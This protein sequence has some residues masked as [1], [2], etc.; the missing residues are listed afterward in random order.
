MKHF[1]TTNF[2]FLHSNDPES[3]E[4]EDQRR[5]ELLMGKE[6]LLSEL[7][8]IGVAY[9]VSISE[10]VE[11]DLT[12][13]KKAE[14]I[15]MLVLDVD[16]VLTDGGMFF[17]EHGDEIKKFNSKDGL[18]IKRL[19]KAGFE[20]GII[21]AANNKH[22]VKHRGEML[23]MERVYVGQQP[24]LEILTQWCTEL[25]L[26]FEQIAYVGD[27]L[28]DIPIMERCGFSAC[29]NNAVAAVRQQADVVLRHNGGDGCVREVIDDYLMSA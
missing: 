10:L 7:L 21:S 16:G 19:M 25:G 14:G 8:A 18:G 2:A 17:S 28:N 11:R 23:G 5:E 27:D 4:L 12:L 29:P 6:P 9:N 1:F 26:T 15:R 13:R 20:A 22:I 3:L 24:K